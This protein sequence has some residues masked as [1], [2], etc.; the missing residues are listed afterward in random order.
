[1]GTYKGI[2]KLHVNLREFWPSVNSDVFKV[3]KPNDEVEI[4][5][6]VIGE[7]Y[8]DSDIWYVLTNHSFVWSKAVYAS[9]EI[10][11]ID[12]KIIV[13]ADDI[14]IVDQIDV[15]AQIALKE[16]W[17]NSLAVLVN[18]PDDP[19]EEYLKRFAETLKNHN[20]NG[21]SKS[22][23]ETTHIGLHFTI[24]SGEPVSD[25]SRIW[26]LVDDDHKFLNFRKFDKKFENSDYVD[27]I[28]LE[29]LAQYEKFK[30]IFGREPDHL[31]SHHDVLTFNNPLFHFMHAWSREKGIPLRNHRFLPSSK[32][33][34]YDTI[35][36]TQVNLPSISTM[37]S[38]E[39]GF[40]EAEFESPQHTVVEHYGPIPP[41]GVTCYESTKRKK[42]EKLIKWTSDFLVSTDSCREI[43]IHLI[44]TDFRDQR[45]FVEFYDPLRSTYPG[46][47]IKYFDGR[48]AEYLSLHE[49]RPWTTHPALD[50][51]PAYFR[52][53]MKSDDCR[54]L[55][56]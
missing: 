52:P 22:L 20:R 48:A 23:F 11:L 34:W 46:I 1:M 30:R 15:G 38:W 21:S 45:E 3:L 39:T 33:F 7:P 36:L 9:S 41:F 43:V 6:A 35:A 5:H 10:P 26:R 4:S 54:A 51:S 12:K 42:Q 17:I 55:K 8:L 44:K 16:G 56:V 32:R 31:T 53:F 24:T 29:F 18:R 49:K 40:G 14:G 28:K 25:W 37:N 19:K 50:L 47:E 27:Q 2:I 13:T